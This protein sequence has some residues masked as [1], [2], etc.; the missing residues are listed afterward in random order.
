M[1]DIEIAFI[2]EIF[3]FECK[4]VS[5]LTARSY[6]FE[7]EQILAKQTESSHHAKNGLNTIA[8]TA[9]IDIPFFFFEVATKI[10]YYVFE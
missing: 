9:V 5:G 3:V 10:E 2:M 4:S 1:I 7:I 8:P 6:W